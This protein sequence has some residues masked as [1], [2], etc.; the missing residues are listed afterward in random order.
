MENLLNCSTAFLSVPSKDKNLTAEYGLLGLKD[1]FF[2]KLISSRVNSSG[3]YSKM[4]RR[5]RYLQTE[6]QLLAARDSKTVLLKSIHIHYIYSGNKEHVG[7]G[8]LNIAVENN[9]RSERKKH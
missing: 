8:F 2:S 6:F 7:Q 9:W 4:Y 5:P 3:F 1:V